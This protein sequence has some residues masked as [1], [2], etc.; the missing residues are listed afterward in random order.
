MDSKREIT[1]FT[2]YF[3]IEPGEDVDPWTH[4]EFSSDPRTF[5][6]AVLPDLT[7][8]ER[9]GVFRDAIRKLNLL[10]PDFVIS[11]GDVIEGH[12]HDESRL[13]SD[14][15]MFFE[16]ARELSAPLFL[17]PGNHDYWYRSTQNW[18]SQAIEYDM[19]NVWEKRVGRSYYHFVFKDVLFLLLNNCFPPEEID[20]RRRQNEFVA[21]IL[22]RYKQVRWTFLFFHYP[23]FANR[24]EPVLE[25]CASALS[26]RRYTVIAGNSH[27]YRYF[28]ID[29][30][31]HI[32][33][34]TTGGMSR[35]RGVRYGEFDHIA[36]ITV[37]DSGPA[38]VNLDLEGI[39]DKRL[40]TDTSAR[41]VAEL[42][43]TSPVSSPF[44]LEPGTFLERRVILTIENP[45]DVSM[46]FA[47]EF[48]QHDLIESNPSSIVV[49][50]APGG[51][52]QIMV[53]LAAREPIPAY[54][55]GAAVF[56]W[57]ARIILPTGHPEVEVAGQHRIVF[58]STGDRPRL[59]RI[60][61]HDD[62]S[63]PRLRPSWKPLGPGGCFVDSGGYRLAYRD[64]LEESA[65]GPYARNLAPEGQ[66]TD[67]KGIW[68]L[69]DLWALPAAGL[70]RDIQ[71]GTFDATVSF[72]NVTW[73]D[74]DSQLKWEFWDSPDQA[75]HYGPKYT[76][77]VCVGVEIRGGS[78]LLFVRRF[79]HGAFV[80]VGVTP[81]GEPPAVFCLRAYWRE[82]RGRWQFAFG[83]DG[84]KPDTPAPGGTVSDESIVSPS[85][86]RNVVY[87]A[88]SSGDGDCFADL[89]RYTIMT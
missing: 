50:L 2:T 52:K 87:I 78:A 43:T 65:G 60:L 34:A 56:G 31:D 69:T 71:P 17:I 75:Y 28:E 62:F 77:G 47:G 74:G 5:R 83:L 51:E 18:D 79:V 19:R 4:L 85:G 80:D 41:I 13:H 68:T 72:E 58:D 44:V 53:D 10:Q 42:L 54:R 88:P 49:T 86:K 21:M 67:G 27:D 32:V 24:R 1:A 7:G 26:E 23:S 57:R 70:F 36:W 30:R 29:G 45:T 82:S 33:V 73:N 59:D 55:V 48:E 11:V 64:V 66:Y 63:G 35:M 76:A 38:I 14:W 22:D 16:S 8:R 12:S 84:A 40:R 39:Y 25:H 46:E 89:S 3:D 81:L 9:P 20:D 15:D 37:S 6:F 61:F